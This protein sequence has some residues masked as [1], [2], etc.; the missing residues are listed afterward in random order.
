MNKPRCLLVDDEEDVL[1]LLKAVVE[2][3][4]NCHAV[5]TLDEA[6]SSLAT[7][8]F[9]L[10]ITDMK[11]TNESG[12]DLVEHIQKKYPIMP[13]AM[14]SGYGDIKTAVKVIQMGAIDFIEKRIIGLL[15]IEKPINNKQ[16]IGLL[17]KAYQL[18]EKR[19][20]I[21]QQLIGNSKQ[22]VELRNKIAI[23]A[24]DNKHSVHIHG[25]T[26]TGKEVVAKMIHHMSPRVNEAFIPVN[27]GAITPELM[28][29]ELFGHI[30]GGFTG[31]IRD[32][33]GLFM[34]ANQGTIFLDEIAD[35]PV[36][37]QSKLLRVLQE[38]RIRPVGA[39]LEIPINVRILSATHGKLKQLVEEEKFREDLYF[40]II[41]GYE[42]YI[43]PLRE[44][45]EDI[46]PLA[47]HIL[48]LDDQN[49]NITISKEA[50]DRLCQY[51]FPGNVR[52]LQTII[53]RAKRNCTDNIIR[54]KDLSIDVPL[55]DQEDDEINE[56]VRGEISNQTNKV[57]G[58]DQIVQKI[59]L[60]VAEKKEGCLV[61][62]NPLNTIM[63]QIEKQVLIQF[64]KEARGNKTRA[65][66]LLGIT[67]GTL[68]FRVEKYRITPEDTQ[69]RRSAIRVA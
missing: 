60:L 42:L 36:N 52:E 2:T 3:K 26:G 6:Y 18:W 15:E 30:K 68:R 13:V 34:A 31:A 45:L 16:I 58:L 35:L 38:N 1:I 69:D 32:R 14:I 56:I 19:S 43:P 29:N 59:Q 21:S 8:E 65:A 28:E 12:I 51:D 49:C 40:R 23:C 11:L 46:E 64:L 41:S 7:Y 53:I 5:N 63:E 55:V 39:E 10:C 62:D 20:K 33:A 25:E 22:I 27:C 24:N 54:A 67:L 57:L 47:I 44:R 37:M 50:I 4:F 9:H 61:D 17:E 66:K 48:N